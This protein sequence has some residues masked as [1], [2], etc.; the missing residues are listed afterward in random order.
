[1]AKK[2]RTKAQRR[3]AALK[4]WKER[5]EREAKGL[6]PVSRRRGKKSRRRPVPVK[7]SFPAAVMVE[8][9]APPAEVRYLP[10]PRIAYAAEEGND[11]FMCFGQDGTLNRERISESIAYKL[12]SELTAILYR[13]RGA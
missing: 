9:P 7:A 4:S 3:A 6:P 13:R 10:A 5:K 11:I 12:V 8:Q 2:A 1:M